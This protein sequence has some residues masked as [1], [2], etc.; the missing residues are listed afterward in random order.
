L[1]N[2][3]TINTSIYCIYYARKE[4]CDALGTDANQPS[5]NVTN[6][7]PAGTE[8]PG[9]KNTQQRTPKPTANASDA[10]DPDP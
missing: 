6:G 8:T 1:Y 10:H 2:E 7:H 5:A 3:N 9:G 4:N